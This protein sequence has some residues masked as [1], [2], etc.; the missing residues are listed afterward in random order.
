MTKLLSTC[1]RPMELWTAEERLWM[2]ALTMTLP[3]MS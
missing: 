3:L 1:G 2:A